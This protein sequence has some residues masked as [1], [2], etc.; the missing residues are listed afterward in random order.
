MFPDRFYAIGWNS[1]G[2]PA[3]NILPF[4]IISQSGEMLMLWNRLW[5]VILILVVLSVVGWNSLAQKQ[6]AGTT[7]EYKIVDTYGPSEMNPPIAADQLNERGR[8]GWELIAIRSAPFPNR[9]SNQIK[10]Q[11]FYKRPGQ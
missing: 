6:S 7:W 5:L 8:E 9:D 10:T 1:D 2:H 4:T 11:L 3:L